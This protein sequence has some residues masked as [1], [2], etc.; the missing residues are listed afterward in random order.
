MKKTNLILGLLLTTM[1]AMTSTLMA[2]DWYNV[3]SAGFSAG[4]AT[5]ISLA[6]DGSGTPYVAYRDGS[7]FVLQDETTVNE[8]YGKR[9]HIDMPNLTSMTFLNPRTFKLGI[10]VNF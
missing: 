10:S 7:E 9:A 3:G 8:L 2:D 6:I 4:G 5:Y 1:L